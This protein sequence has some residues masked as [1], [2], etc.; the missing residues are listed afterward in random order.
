MHWTYKMVLQPDI[1]T[2]LLSC[3]SEISTTVKLQYMTT[4]SENLSTNLNSTSAAQSIRTWLEDQKVAG[5]S[6]AWTGRPGG[7]LV[8]DANNRA[9]PKCL[10][11]R[12][13]MPNS[14]GC[15]TAVN[16]TLWHEDEFPPE[17]INEGILL[18]TKNVIYWT[19]HLSLPL[20]TDHVKTTLQ[21]ATTSGLYQ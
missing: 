3:I 5:L 17:G 8:A 12:Q 9:L 20:F 16:D 2:M 21:N 4:F 15:W 13:L 10:W 19:S 6:P 1:K 18:L 11:A 7:C 14:S